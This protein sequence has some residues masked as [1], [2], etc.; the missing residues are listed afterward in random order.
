MSCLTHVV[1]LV[2][3]FMKKGRPFGALRTSQ[4]A[5]IRPGGSGEWASVCCGDTSGESSGGAYTVGFTA[6]AAAAA[7]SGG[8]CMSWNTQV[9]GQ[10]TEG[11][12]GEIFGGIP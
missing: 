9:K 11:W 1:V 8:G 2:E 12:A 3:W 6:A 4:P 10:G 7:G 5:G